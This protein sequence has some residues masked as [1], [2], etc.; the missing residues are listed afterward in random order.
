M[1][2]SSLDIL[3]KMGAIWIT[4]IGSLLLLLSTFLQKVFKH[5]IFKQFI[6]KLHYLCMWYLF[7]FKEPLIHSLII[8]YFILGHSGKA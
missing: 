5:E 4:E 1:K 6:M 8:S 7:F 3:D 2:L